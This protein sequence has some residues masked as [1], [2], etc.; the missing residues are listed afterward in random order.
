MK[1]ESVLDLIDAEGL[2]EIPAAAWNA[3]RAHAL[4]CGRCA[5]AFDAAGRLDA[6][7]RMLDRPTL[8]RDFS[9]D[10]MQEILRAQ[11]TRPAEY[12][13][14]RHT[15]RGSNIF[16][17]G[18]PAGAFAVAVLAWAAA[19]IGGWAS[20][21]TSVRLAQPAWLPTQPLGAAVVWLALGLAFS[22]F[23]WR[24]PVRRSE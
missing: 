2:T 3:A 8:A 1:C 22:V 19:P 17:W 9:V 13:A 14:R 16:G 10:V 18:L 20:A 6:R 12:P 4:Q 7:L 11:A 15:L 24:A 21:L 5:E 23:A